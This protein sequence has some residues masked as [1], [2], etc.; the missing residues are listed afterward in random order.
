MSGGARKEKK[1]EKKKEKRKDKKMEKKKE[2]EVKQRETATLMI[3]LRMNW[4]QYLSA[5]T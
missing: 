3:S 5:R 1:K 2:K 4:L